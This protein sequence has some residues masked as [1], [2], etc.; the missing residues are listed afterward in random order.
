MVNGWFYGTTFYSLEFHQTEV[1]FFPGLNGN[2]PRHDNA[3][4]I[5]PWYC[6]QSMQSPYISPKG[7]FNH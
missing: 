7:F 1:D 5:W 3:M 4:S 2:R 6:F